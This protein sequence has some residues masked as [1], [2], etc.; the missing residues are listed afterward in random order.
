LKPQQRDLTPVL[1][2]P[3]EPAVEMRTLPDLR[4]PWSVNTGRRLDILNVFAQGVR[5]YGAIV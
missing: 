2:R 5:V 3:V 4:E 1:R